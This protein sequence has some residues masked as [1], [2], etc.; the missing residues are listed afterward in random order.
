[1]T[2]KIFQFVNSLLT[3]FKDLNLPV[4]TNEVITNRI[5]MVSEAAM[6]C[7]DRVIRSVLGKLFLKYFVD[8]LGKMT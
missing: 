3:T 5:D 1:M 6:G 4:F 8:T 2:Y 7:H